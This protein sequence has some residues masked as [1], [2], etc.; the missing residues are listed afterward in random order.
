[1]SQVIPTSTDLTDYSQVT[2][3]DGRDYILRFLHNQRENRWYL[4]LSDQDGI[5]IVD[6]IKIVVGISL[7]RKVTDVRRPPGLLFARDLTAR[8]VVDFDAG[9]QTLEED[10]K[11]TDLGARVTLFYFTAAEIV[12]LLGL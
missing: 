3:L 7:L 1:M 8:D 4:N 12:A 10:P 9:D 11:L 2:T 6:G 5:S